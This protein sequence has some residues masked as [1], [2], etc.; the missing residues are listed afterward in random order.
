MVKKISSAYVGGALGALVDS[1]NIWFLGKI[2][3]TALIGVGLRP[4]FK[5]EWLYPR[6]VWGGI[7]GLLLL[8]RFFKGSTSLRGILMSFAPT[9]IMFF[10][11]FTSVLSQ[12]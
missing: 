11:V 7:W 10:V 8:L 3:F 5:V 1:L 4:A 2:G 6:L 12:K 9:A